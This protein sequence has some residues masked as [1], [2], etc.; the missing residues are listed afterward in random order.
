MAS[1]APNLVG[2]PV[3][4]LKEHAKVQPDPSFSL[5]DWVTQAGRVHKAAVDADA[6][7]QI[8]QAYVEYMKAAR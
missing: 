8:E 4:A 2:L 6:R 1:R 3:A 5:K 7:G